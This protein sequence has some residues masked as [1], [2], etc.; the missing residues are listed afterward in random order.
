M[1][2]CPSGGRRHRKLGA[3]QRARAE[4]GLDLRELVVVVPERRDHRRDHR[5]GLEGALPR[6]HPGREV[7]DLV[8]RRRLHRVDPEQRL[9][10]VG[11]PRLVLPDQ[12]GDIR[13]DLE[14]ARVLDRPVVR[15]MRLD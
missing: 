14:L 12:A 15:D 6:G 4:V 2:W 11:L 9:G 8:E 10:D 3:G 5:A 1:P 13:L 7:D